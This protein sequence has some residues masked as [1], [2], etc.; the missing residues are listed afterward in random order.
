MA[1]QIPQNVA[2]EQFKQELANLINYFLV[3]LKMPVFLVAEGIKGY[4]DELQV[5]AQKE[6]QQALQEYNKQLE[7]E[8][9][10]NTKNKEQG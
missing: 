8:K 6:L 2:Y 1:V 4:Y 7:Q 9:K 5:Q 3:D 10:Q